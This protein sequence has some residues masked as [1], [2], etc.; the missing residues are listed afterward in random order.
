MPLPYFLASKFDAFYDRGGNDPRTS[1][2]FEDITYLLN[3]TSQ[4]TAIIQKCQ[5]EVQEYLKISFQQILDSK[6]LHE[7][8]I[9]NLFYEDQ[10]TRLALILDKLQNTVDAL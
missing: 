5:K 8:I 2:D 10:T 6:E 3:H 7:A 9:G 4:I 1:H